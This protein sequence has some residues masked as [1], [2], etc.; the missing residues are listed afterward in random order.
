MENEINNKKLRAA[1]YVR[2]S[3][4]EQNTMFWHINQLSKISDYIKSRWDN[5]EFAWKK[6]DF[7]D[8]FVFYDKISWTNQI[9]DREAMA[10]MFDM[11]DY[12]ADNPFDLIIVYKIDRF[13]RS[14][15][16]LLDIVE[17][18]KKKKINFISTQESIDTSSPFGNAMLW[19]LWVFAELD[20]DMIIERTWWWIEKSFEAWKAKKVPYW[21]RK[22]K[23]GRPVILKEESNVIE[24]I[25]NDFVINWMNISTICIKLKEEK[26]LIPTTSG[27]DSSHFNKIKWVYEWTDSTIRKILS[28]EFYIWKFYHNKSKTVKQENWKK[29]M[30]HLPKLEWK[31][32]KHIHSS[33]IND[34]IFT[35]AQKLLSSKKWNKNR[36]KSNYLLSS[37]LECWYCEDHRP[38]WVMSWAWTDWKYYKCSWKKTWNKVEWYLCPVVQL[39]RD[40]LESLVVNEIKWIFNNLDLLKSFINSKNTKENI[41]NIKEK[42]LNKI[43]VKLEENEKALNNLKVLWERGYIDSFQLKDRLDKNE[44]EKKN[45]LNEQKIIL[46]SMKNYFNEKSYKLWLEI[47]KK[48]TQTSFDELFL[49]KTKLKLFL[50]F[51]IEDI[52]IYSRDKLPTDVIRWW[53]TSHKQKVPYKIKIKFKL[54]QDFLREYI[55]FSIKWE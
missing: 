39:P 10:R 55:K 21:Y 5:I 45:L 47:V 3:T 38:H 49:D 1:I 24:R 19:I 43:S 25:F 4:V 40:E 13:A 18:L 35:K 15:K 2:V 14:L 28:N 54:P 42:E 48:I 31:L 32:S 33:I 22:D 23:N 12:S 50:E 29:K 17:R 27:S 11:I 26:I 34:D 9:K 20:K 6:I 44:G 53:P 46:K 16:I 8:E 41:I 30:V 37:L 7:D 52:Y 36:S 51:I